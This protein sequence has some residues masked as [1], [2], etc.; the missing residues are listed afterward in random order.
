VWFRSVFLK[1]LH[2]CRVAILGWGLGLGA[3][4]PL[5]FL[6]VPTL[7][8]DAESRAEILAVVQHPAM[9]LFAEP[10]DVLEPGGYATWRMSLVLPLM[11]LWALLAAS[12]MVRG[13]EQS[14]SLD[15]LL[16]T[17][18]SR[19]R[20]VTQKVAAIAVALLA[21]GGLIGLLAR[22]GASLAR[23]DLGLDAALLFGLNAALLAMVF[24]AL[25]LLISQFTRERRTA[26]GTAGALLGLSMVLTS[27]GRVVP[28]GAW[29]GQI[30]PLYY[31]ELSKPLVPSYGVSPHAMLVL[32]ALAAVLSLIAVA[33]FVRRDVG[34]SI[35]L[36]VGFRRSGRRPRPSTAVP[37]RS[38]SLRSVFARSLAALGA[39]VVSWSLALSIYAALLT[40]ILRQA[41][42]N[43]AGL[44]QSLSRRDPLYADMIARLTGGGDTS[45]NAGFLSVIF[46]LLA[47]SVAACAVT[48]ANRWAA[49]EEDG[50]LELLLATPRRRQ[51]VIL[52]RYTAVVVALL[53]VA[54]LIFTSVALTGSIVGMTLDRGRLAQAAFAMVPIAL[55][56]VAVGYLLSGWLRTAAVTGTLTSWLVGSFLVTLLG[57]L[58]KWPATVLRLSLFE[59]YGTPLVDGLHVRDT[60][61]LLVLAAGT[62]VIATVR[63]ATKDLAH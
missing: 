8:G 45:A 17:P 20:V 40:A 55:L 11:S 27:A 63:F 62:L 24:G 35:E 46:T 54:G 37:L 36:P 38:W 21:M 22:A 42:Q 48:L 26:A 49:E 58:F 12:R 56:V 7:L 47:V 44:F 32:A 52:A 31:F 51:R 25:A 5:I 30:S 43:I 13:E 33:L 19:L 28:N 3:M 1:T 16:S 60:L 41:Q 50:R 6:I 15:V 39:T 14:G 9:R 29:I 4:T 2:D 10:V 18:R 61:G 53:T 34:G 57:P 59:H 23:V